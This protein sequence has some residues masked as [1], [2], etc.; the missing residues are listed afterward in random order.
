MGVFFFLLSITFFFFSYLFLL[1][2]WFMNK[3]VIKFSS[4]QAPERELI[5]HLYPEFNVH[6]VP[7]DFAPDSQANDLCE[8]PGVFYLSPSSLYLF[9]LLSFLL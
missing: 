6:A 9:S 8:T 1:S 2:G 3:I 5:R 7:H 4:L